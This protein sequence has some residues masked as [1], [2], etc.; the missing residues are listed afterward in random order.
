MGQRKLDS[1]PLKA[2]FRAKIACIAL[3][4]FAYHAKAQDFTFNIEGG[5][6]G[7]PEV[8]FL[9]NFNILQSPN[10]ADDAPLFRVTLTTTRDEPTNV[11][12]RF[13]LARQK[14]SEFI[15]EAESKPFLFSSAQSPLTITNI[16]IT[17]GTGLNIKLAFL[18][19]NAEVAKE[20]QDAILRTGRLPNDRYTLK[21]ELI[22]LDIPDAN[23]PPIVEIIDISNPTTLDLFG[24]GGPVSRDFCQDVFTTFPQ[25][26]WN[27]NA[28]KFI[29]TVCQVT[30]EN[31]SP[32]D[33][34]QNEPRARL[35]IQRDVDFF[36]TP[37]VVYPASGVWP[38]QEGQTYYWQVQAIVEAP[39]ADVVIPSEIWC[40]RIPRLDAAAR[41]VMGASTLNLLRALL[42]GTPFEYL[43]A[44]DGPLHG[45]IP[46][47]TMRFNNRQIGI[48][49]LI[50]LIKSANAGQLKIVNSKV[51]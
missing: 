5:L 10:S 48:F 2:A 39:G 9:T 42:S 50:E 30:P 49:D 19:Y 27:S 35:T 44:E 3:S 14:D 24:P 11:K 4:L 34:M 12:L 8:V 32:E 38:L 15:V 25:F 36:G 37:S 20:L 23:P 17:S 6:I 18:N 33:V 47:G 28:D 51:E 22:V 16:D 7:S 26:S 13:T 43:I 1:P 45:Y 46:T 40:F 21:V 29:L 41:Q 31:A